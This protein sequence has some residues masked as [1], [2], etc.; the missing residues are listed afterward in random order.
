M[1]GLCVVVQ[2]FCVG[3]A[4]HFVVIA[5]AVPVEIRTKPV[6]A[7]STF[8]EGASTRIEVQRGDVVVASQGV[9]T[10]RARAEFA[11][12]IVVRSLSIV[13]ACLRECATL[14]HTNTTSAIRRICVVVVCQGL[15]AAQAA[16]PIACAT[17]QGLS[18]K[19]TC[20]RIRAT[21]ARGVL[22]RSIVVQR[23]GVVVACAHDIAPQ[24]ET[25][26]VVA[27]L[28]CQEVAGVVVCATLFSHAVQAGEVTSTGHIS[29]GIRIVVACKIDHAA[30]HRS[31]DA[32]AVVDVGIRVVVGRS[33]IHA[34]VNLQLVT[35]AIVV[36][37]IH[38]VAITI[39]E[40]FRI[41]TQIEV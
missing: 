13:V 31:R 34:T 25:R 17:H 1:V 22:A 14:E 4:T 24:G 28:L 38:T 21:C 11:T 18:V 19:I 12:A 32:R 26:G 41:H 7:A 40:H 29:R 15:V 10:S 3:A 20:S 6:T 33:F 9:E 36:E 23:L 37:I 8:W 5:N 39:A 30:H 35:N 2:R 27:R 16:F